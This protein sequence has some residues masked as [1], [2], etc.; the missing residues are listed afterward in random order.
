MRKPGKQLCSIL[1]ILIMLIIL[2]PVNL[3]ATEGEEKAVEQVASGTETSAE[4]ESDII[5]EPE[6]ETS[7]EPESET[8]AEPESE[9]SAEVESDIIAEPESETSAEPESDII[10]EP[11]S[12][13]SAEPESDIIAEPESETSAEPEPDISAPSESEQFETTETNLSRTILSKD[14]SNT[15]FTPNTTVIGFAGHQWWVI[16]DVGSGVKSQLRGTTTSSITLWSKDLDF[17]QIPFN[18]NST[19]NDANKYDGSTLQS[20]MGGL[21]VSMFSNGNAQEQNYLIKREAE[22]IDQDA[23]SYKTG[24][25]GN[26]EGDGIY[27][28]GSVSSDQKFW[29]LSKGEWETVGAGLNGW[30]V[31]KYGNFSWLRSPYYPDKTHAWRGS[32]AGEFSYYSVVSVTS[33]YVRPAF[34]LDTSSVLFTSA[35]SGKSM[36][37]V[38]A[39]PDLVDFQNLS[40]TDTIKLTMEET[41]PNKLNLRSSTR[42]VTSSAEG[43]V[44]IEYSGAITGINK[45]VSIMICNKS[46]GK[47]MYYGR[48]VNL[49][50]NAAPG[51]TGSG[52]ATFKVPTGLDIGDYTLK[53]FNEEVNGDNYTDYAS[54]PQSIPLKIREV[55]VGLSINPTT[56]VYIGDANHTVDI[57]AEVVNHTDI[58]GSTIENVKWFCVPANG[59]DDYSEVNVFDAEYLRNSNKGT[60]SASS[61]S[62]T[63]A[64]FNLK[65]NQNATYWFKGT[66]TDNST[67]PSKT[68]T[69]VESITVDNIYTTIPI[70]VRGE[71]SDSRP[72]ELYSYEEISGQH[73]IPYDLDSTTEEPKVVT[74]PSHGYDLVSLEANSQ[75]STHWNSAMKSGTGLPLTLT[76]DSHFFSNSECDE[77]YK[78][79]T[80]VY[81]KN[82]NDWLEIEAHFVDE[83]GSAITSADGLTYD[84]FSAPL[85]AS[86]G[87]SS[88]LTDGGSYSQPSITDYTVIGYRVGS[89][90]GEL[91]SCANFT[92]FNP[93]IPLGTT[94]VYIVYHKNTTK[95][96]IKKTVKGQYGDPNQQ[97]DVTITMKDGGTPVTG[98]YDC[99]SVIGSAITTGSVPFNSSG[100]GILKLKHGQTITI[101]GIPL[102]YTYTVEET[103][104]AVFNG[105]Y[106]VS[107]SS[108][109]GTATITT[110]GVADTLVSTIEEVSITNSRT[111]IPALGLSG[112]NYRVVI[113]GIMVALT[114]AVTTLW[115][116]RRR[117][118]CKGNSE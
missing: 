103:D 64:T 44:D 91:V 114:V 88:F 55:T 80:I 43:T 100:Q 99:T 85:D 56:K 35:A 62:G 67:A 98:L 74:S 77:D 15:T 112:I 75:Y 70:Y 65:V 72:I 117:R 66:V 36:K 47:S 30:N 41:D 90:N 27:K 93:N 54:T 49:D 19:S 45:S 6:S 109:S 59:S 73:G 82:P 25:N 113:A 48:L 2:L 50:P 8:S 52:K 32:A 18:S 97:F 69:V 83:S 42:I 78:E 9:T 38:S 111:S 106:S 28:Y 84:I 102:G 24:T 79:Y 40:N 51:A 39:A 5:A 16:G 20:Y 89:L 118:K 17:D 94:D 26:N 87:V 107:Y 95:L 14:G 101:E 81:T 10:A 31:R 1:L 86:G 68:Y 21:D 58:T 105:I 11:E 63:T 3:S 22:S 57:T 33:V 116:Y 4:A 60:I 96:A 53:I 7:A 104:T 34:Y 61:P 115:C 12:E 71:T 46:T 76:L 37:P 13:T 110:T 23:W 108:T 92:D 29:P